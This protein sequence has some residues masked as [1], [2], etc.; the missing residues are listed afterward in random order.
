MIEK[1]LK[2]MCAKNCINRWSS[3]KALHK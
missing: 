2:Y 1:L 3:D